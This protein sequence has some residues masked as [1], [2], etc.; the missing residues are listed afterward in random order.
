MARLDA[1]VGIESLTDSVVQNT[2]YAGTI[3]LSDEDLAVVPEA[4]L[5]TLVASIR[6]AVDP[7]PELV[8]QVAS[9]YSSEDPDDAL[10]LLVERG[11]P[12][13]LYSS[14]P[15]WRSQPTAQGVVRIL[16][17][18]AAGPQATGV[19]WIQFLL[20]I[21]VDL[22]PYVQPAGVLDRGALGVAE[23]FQSALGRSWTDSVRNAVLTGA[24]GDEPA[25]EYAD[26]LGTGGYEPLGQVALLASEVAALRN[27]SYEASAHTPLSEDLKVLLAISPELLR[28]T[29]AARRL[30]A[31]AAAVSAHPD[32]VSLQWCLKVHWALGICEDNPDRSYRRKAQYRDVLGVI[33]SVVMRVLEQHSKDLVEEI[34]N[35][36]PRSWISAPPN[37]GYFEV[38]RLLRNRDVLSRSQIVDLIVWAGSADIQILHSL[39]LGSDG[40]AI[41]EL[42][43]T[44]SP[45]AIA[46]NRHEFS[47]QLAEAGVYADW[48]QR[49]VTAMEENTVRDLG[50]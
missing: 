14:F 22:R 40:P 42:V 24:Y 28:N 38:V 26:F 23:A 16:E 49:I 43:R 45:R 7:A 15:H 21:G 3:Q 48:R 17:N 25:F 29:H 2:S 1:Q 6:A 8:M 44:R 27:G 39:R 5:R 47:R 20:E 50:A 12:P 33:S 4:M 31:A 35:S 19:R 18:I 9:W 46:A 11:V 10:M 32:Q 13:Y 30:I 34:I 36:D 41:A 37:Y